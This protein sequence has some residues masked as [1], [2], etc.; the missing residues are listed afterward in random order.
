[1]KKDELI[2]KFGESAEGNFVP[3][4]TLGHPHPYCI[5]PRHLKGDRMYLDKDAIREAEKKFGAKC[6]V[7]GC[8]LSYDE[9]K[10]ILVL[11]CKKDPKEDEQAGK[12]L[13]EYLLKIKSTLMNDDFEGVAF[14]K[15]WEGGKDGKK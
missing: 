11:A 9:H 2:K 6:G 7:K 5:T 1:M 10:Q 15:Q 12:E 8:N 3:H 4:D 14:M 13:H